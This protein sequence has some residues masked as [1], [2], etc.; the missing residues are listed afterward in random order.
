[1]YVLY[2]YICICMFYTYMYVHMNV[3]TYFL[4]SSLLFEICSV[5]ASD[6]RMK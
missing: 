3:Y 6:F 4:V 2:A 1:M 5:T